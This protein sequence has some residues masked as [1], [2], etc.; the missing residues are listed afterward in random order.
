MA[1]DHCS[2]QVSNIE[3]AI[4]FYTDKLGFK[5]LFLHTNEAVREYYA[6]L[7]FDGARLE[8]I[9]DMDGEFKKPEINKHY[10]PHFCLE[11]DD[12]KSVIADLEQ[13]DI[14]I[15]SGPNLLED[16][17]TW[18]YIKDPDNNVLEYIEWLNCLCRRTVSLC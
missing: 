12:L 10:C 15:L 11:V 6:F 2:F 3:D 17:E 8:L 7:E 14:S 18:L 16:E 1:F 5:L 13:N 4:K 9:Q